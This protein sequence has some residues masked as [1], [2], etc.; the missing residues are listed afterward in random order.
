MAEPLFGAVEAVDPARPL[1]LLGPGGQ[2]F[3]QALGTASSR[4]RMASRCC[5]G[6]TRESTSESREHLVDGELSVGDFVLAGGE[7]AALVV[8]E[9]VARLVPGVMGNDES[10]TRSRSPRACSSTRSTP[11][12][13]SSGDGPC[14][15]CCARGT[16]AGSPGGAVPGRW[17]G[18][19][20]TAR[21]SS[22]PGAASP[23]RTSALLEEFGFPRYR[24][25]SP[26]RRTPA[27]V[28][29]AM[30]PTDLD[31]SAIPPQR[32]PRLRARRQPQ[33]PRASGR[34]QP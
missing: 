24:G 12:P 11:G 4:R 21:T 27:G 33:G 17:P 8:I 30:K 31:R 26:P 22:K 16:T 14:P 13:P 5:A 18:R 10:A 7:V 34:G 25:E 2:R 19:S 32:R 1:Y 28:E 6:A 23:S 29:R 3:D 15:T 20:P 9:A